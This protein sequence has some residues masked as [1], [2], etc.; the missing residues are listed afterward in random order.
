M[1]YIAL[2]Y[3]LFSDGFHIKNKTLQKVILLF[4]GQKL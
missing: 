2:S 3:M 1:L 4:R